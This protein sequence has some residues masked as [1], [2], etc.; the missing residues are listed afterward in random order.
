VKAPTITLRKIEQEIDLEDFFPG[1][2][3][4]QER[5]LKESIGQAIIDRIASRTEAGDGMK[6]SASG[7]GRSV[8]LKSP[9]SKPYVDSLEFKAA[10]KKKN[11][12]NMSLTGDMLA[13]MGIEVGSDGKFT[14]TLDDD[15]VPK[16][17]NH[18]TGDTVPERPWFGISKAELKSILSDYSAEIKAAAETP[19]ETDESGDN[20]ARLLALDFLS[21][22]GGD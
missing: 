16:A 17:F 4:S 13:A 19:G 3:F 12:V 11:K 9:Y 18:L 2:D 8:A 20:P 21:D 6:F 5:S 7:Q 10:G 1:V 15:Q 14:I 22:E